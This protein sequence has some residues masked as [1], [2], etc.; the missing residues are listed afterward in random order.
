MVRPANFLRLHG[1]WM[2]L[3]SGKSPAA[4]QLTIMVP[5]V[6]VPEIPIFDICP[7]RVAG[8]QALQDTATMTLGLRNWPATRR[9][10]PWISEKDQLEWRHPGGR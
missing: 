2:D 6:Y 4:R 7:S 3:S 9:R 5:M 8:T 1:W 10:M